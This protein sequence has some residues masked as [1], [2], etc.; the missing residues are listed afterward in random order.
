[1]CWILET[2]IQSGWEISTSC[3]TTVT[4]GFD[5][6]SYFLKKSSSPPLH[7]AQVAAVVID[8]INGKVEVLS[9]RR[10]E[11]HVDINN[12]VH[13][14]VLKTQLLSATPSRTATPSSRCSTNLAKEIEAELKLSEKVEAGSEAKVPIKKFAKPMFNKSA[15]DDPKCPSEFAFPTLRASEENVE[16]KVRDK[17]QC[18]RLILEIAHLLFCRQWKLI[19][20][21][22]L[23]LQN[24]A[25][26]K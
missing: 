13:R 16:Q 14:A 25:N 15:R 4:P 24:S 20:H 3:V 5:V 10:G 1:M 2:L 19:C 17:V 23:P 11:K 18:S 21:S 7:N 9:H 6:G 22:S 8:E 12:A 26:S